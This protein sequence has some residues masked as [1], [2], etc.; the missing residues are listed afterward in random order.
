MRNIKHINIS[1]TLFSII[2]SYILNWYFHPQEDAAILF[3]YSENLANSGVISYNLYA[4]ATEGATDFLWMIILSFFYKIG[5]D[6]F[7]SAILINLIS[8]IFLSNIFRKKFNLSNEYIL[9]IFFLHF[10]FG[11]FWASI[12]GFSILLIE[13]VLLLLMI[14]T[15]EENL[16]KILFFSF[17]GTLLRP[18]FFLFIFFINTYFFFKSEFREKIIIL[19]FVLFGILYFFL[20]YKYFGELFPLPFYVKTQWILIENLGWLKQLLIYLPAII[21]LFYV[22]FNMIFKGKNLILLLSVIIIPTIY[23]ANNVLYQNVGQRFYFYFSIFFLLILFKYFSN[24]KEIIL[25]TILILIFL[26]SSLLNL[27]FEK[28]FI[29]DIKNNLGKHNSNIFLLA[30][31]LKKIKNIKLATTEAGLLPYYSGIFTTDLFGLNDRRFA[32]N[33]AGGMYLEENNYDLIIINSSQFGTL[34]KNLNFAIDKARNTTPK[35]YLDRKSDWNTFTLNL[36]SGVTSNKY[37]K[38]I[39]PYYSKNTNED[40]NTFIFLNMYS[41]NFHEIDELI[42]IKGKNCI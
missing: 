1:L 23:Y 19:I 18:D 26:S 37:K 17:I 31:K 13:L 36:L 11:F 10:S 28:E 15:Y 32:K 40:K 3:R 27:L 41:K 22:R 34:C 14:A 30:K 39:Y 8:L 33:P 16:N 9:I 12:F 25:K 29:F 35:K 20:R 42:A 5:L 21:Y 4:Q 6:T 2:I 24:K 38:Y 7:F